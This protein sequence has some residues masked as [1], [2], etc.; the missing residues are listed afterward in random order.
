MGSLRNP[1]CYWILIWSIDG[2]TSDAVWIASGHTRE[3]LSKKL[4]SSQIINVDGG[5]FPEDEINLADPIRIGAPCYIP[6]QR[7]ARACSGLESC[8]AIL[9]SILI[10]IQQLVTCRRDFRIALS[11]HSILSTVCAQ[12]RGG[13]AS[14]K[15]HLYIGIS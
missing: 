9:G 3:I 7:L 4:V 11:R 6:G 8:P 2:C 13:T 1:F 12:D 15:H 14:F 5:V 10:P